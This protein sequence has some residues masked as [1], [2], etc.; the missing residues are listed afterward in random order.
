MKPDGLIC[1]CLIDGKEGRPILATRPR[2]FQTC[3]NDSSRRSAE[4]PARHGPRVASAGRPARAR[5][6]SAQEEL[7]LL[8]LL[9]DEALLLLV[10]KIKF[11][12]DR[13]FGRLRIRRLD[14]QDI[15]RAS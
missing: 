14:C 12:D 9:Y 2:L 1:V 6:P 3:R 13:R 8:A 7:G 15:G 4:N 10:A 5:Y 11:G